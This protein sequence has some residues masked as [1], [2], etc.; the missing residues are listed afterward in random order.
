MEQPSEPGKDLPQRLLKYL[1]FLMLSHVLVTVPTFIISIAL[2]Y[3]T[4]VQ[5]DA[6]RKIQLSET[7]PYIAFGTSN[8]SPDGKA[9]ISI[10]MTNNGVGPARLE[11]MELTYNGRPIA[12]P[13][14]LLRACCAGEQR[15]SFMTSPVGGVLRPG[16]TRQFIRVPKT[17]DNAAIWERLNGERWKIS[18][19]SCYCS[20]FDDCWVLE[21]R[22]DNSLRGPEKVKACPAGWSK[23]EEQPH[24]VV[25]GP[26]G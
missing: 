21:S 7:W 14:E 9:E 10:N 25:S 4:F 17:A 11:Q 19:R 8:A 13:R 3:A 5:A 15:L 20:I 12:S 26:A 22:L 16:E 1:P 2:A 6:T 18:V 24:P 23:F